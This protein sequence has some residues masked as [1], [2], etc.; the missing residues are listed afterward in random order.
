M[1]T[2]DGAA[3]FAPMAFTTQEYAEA[4]SVGRASNSGS[5]FLLRRYD[6]KTGPKVS[7]KKRSYRGS[8]A[9]FPSIIFSSLNR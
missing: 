3:G 5:Y 7:Y 6:V 1:S 8:S 4:I 9:S 2:L